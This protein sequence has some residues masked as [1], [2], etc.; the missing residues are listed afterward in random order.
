MLH[1]SC[2]LYTDIDINS[3]Q[4]LY[5]LSNKLGIRQSIDGT[6]VN[7]VDV[8]KATMKDCGGVPIVIFP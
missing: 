7:V 3:L 1:I 6:H 4:N 8:S 2:S 5:F